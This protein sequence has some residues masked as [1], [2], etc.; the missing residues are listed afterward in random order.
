M[1]LKHPPVDTE[2]EVM[3]SFVIDHPK[4][5]FADTLPE[6]RR[7]VADIA[8]ECN[9]KREP[10]KRVRDLTFRYEADDRDMVTDVQ[11]FFQG[12]T[13]KSIRFMRL[14]RN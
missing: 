5:I 11:V 12:Y 2:W 10:K 3:K 7:K 1:K 4:S 13:G 8:R 9:L 6:L 14:R